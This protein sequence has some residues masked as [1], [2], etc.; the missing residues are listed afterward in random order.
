MRFLALTLKLSAWNSLF[1]FYT[2]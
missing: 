2:A 1:P